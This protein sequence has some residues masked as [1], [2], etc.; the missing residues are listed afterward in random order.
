MIH[1]KDSADTYILRVLLIVPSPILSDMPIYQ[2]RFPDLTPERAANYVDDDFEKPEQ[3]SLLSG[4]I[5]S[6]RLRL[7]PVIDHQKAVSG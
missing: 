4:N 6:E 1:K 2:T 3:D 7:E 5:A